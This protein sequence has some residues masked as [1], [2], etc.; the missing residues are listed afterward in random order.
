MDI[1]NLLS[2][3]D[4]NPAGR[5]SKYRGGSTL[6]EAGEAE[7]RRREIQAMRWSLGRQEAGIIHLMQAKNFFQRLKL[8]EPRRN[9]AGVVAWSCS[10]AALQ[11]AYDQAKMCCDPQWAHHPKRDTGFK[12]L[13][14]AMD[15]LSDRNGRREAY[16]AQVAAEVEERD[17]RLNAQFEAA[18]SKSTTTGVGPG[19]AERWSTAAA[20]RVDPGAADVAAELDAQEVG[21]VRYCV[22]QSDLHV[23]SCAHR[24][25]LG[26]AVLHEGGR[27]HPVLEAAVQVRR[28]LRCRRQSTR[29]HIAHSRLAHRIQH[30]R[31]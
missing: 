3:E 20:P 27:R 22:A 4:D 9:E 6:E 19:V 14:E 29:D 16:V 15:T 26:A 30:S 8:P 11:R 10:E 21:R 31:R 5:G 13:T 7:E 12:L 17:A 18:Q 24:R 25:E 23:G 1:L 2:Q 28:L